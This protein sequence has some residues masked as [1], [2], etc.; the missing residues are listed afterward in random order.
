M[1]RENSPRRVHSEAAR[2]HIDDG[3]DSELSDSR[4][5]TKVNTAVASDGKE[6]GPY[7]G[8][9]KEPSRLTIAGLDYI[10]PSAFPRDVQECFVWTEGYGIASSQAA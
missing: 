9:F 10:Q 1:E 8:R 7:R 3:V 2:W 4:E 6:V 5:F